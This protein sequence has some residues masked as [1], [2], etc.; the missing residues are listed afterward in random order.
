MSFSLRLILALVCALFG[1]MMI[2]IAPSEKA[3]FF[4]GFG[5]FCLAIAVTCFTSGRL[6]DFFGSL[7]GTSVFLVAIWYVV[8]V[9]FEGP[10]ATGRRSEPSIVNALLFFAAFGLPAAAFVWKARFG[11]GKRAPMSTCPEG[12][13]LYPECLFIVKITGAEIV[14]TRPDGTI[15]RVNV[16]EL[17]EI[18]IETNDSGPAGADVW[19]ILLGSNPETK[20]AYPGGATGEQKMQEWMQGLR[21]FDNEA[22]I[23]A[24]Q[25]TSNARFICW[26][27]SQTL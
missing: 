18:A 12:K 11:L 6:A 22:V 27:P 19:W 13:G 25:C 15:E 14:S 8:S 16:D 5:A 3:P 4:Y 26:Q 1:V 17:K 2:A 21:G 7:I 24:M 10:L 23:S 20:C 9:L